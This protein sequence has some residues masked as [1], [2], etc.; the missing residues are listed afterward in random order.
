MRLIIL[1][2]LSTLTYV[3]VAQQCK[4]ENYPDTLTK[5][6][7]KDLF[8]LSKIPPLEVNKSLLK[9]TLP[10][11]VDNSPLSYFRPI[12]SQSDYCCGQAA[13]ILY[14]FTYEINR[15]RNLP[16][17]TTANQYPT[18]FA[19]NWQNG[20]DCNRGVSYMNSLEML[21]HTGTPNVADWGG[22]PD[23]GGGSRWLSGYTQYYNGMH[24]KVD[25]YYSFHVGNVEG[26]NVLK[27]WLH[28][29]NENSAV[30]GV[31]CIYIQ[32]TTP[33]QL[34]PA[35]TP[36]AGKRVITQWGASANHGM[37]IVGYNDSICWDYNNDGQ[38]TNN[39]DINSDGIVDMKD[40]EIGG[41]KVANDFGTG[42][43]N[44]GYCYV[45]YKT[46]ADKYGQGGIWNNAVHVVKPKLAYSPLMTIKAT[47]E[48]TSRQEISVEA[49]VSSNVTDTVP[50]HTL[51]R[52][53][54]NFQGGDNYMQ[55][56]TPSALTLPLEFGLDVTPL[57]NY[58]QSGQPARFFFRVKEYDRGTPNDGQITSL[59]LKDYS[60]VSISPSVPFPVA[61]Q[62]NSTT[63]LWMDHTPVFVRPEIVEDTLP[64]MTLY[65]DFTYQMTATN[66][67]PPYKWKMK[68][69]Y[70]EQ[71]TS[72]TYPNISTTVL[73]LNG[74][75]T[76][77]AEVNLNFN[78][79]FY[80]QTYNKMYVHTDGFI[81]F[82][83]ENLPWVYYYDEDKST[84]LKFMKGI[85]VFLSE[86]E[87]LSAPNGTWIEQYSDSVV[88]RWCGT[89]PD[90]MG[91]HYQV[92]F[93]IKLRSDGSINYY[94]GN[95]ETNGFQWAA[96][97][98]NG[99]YANWQQLAFSNSTFT[100]TGNKS[101][102]L[103]PANLNFLNDVTLSETGLLTGIV[104]ESYNNYPLVIEV[105]DN[106][107]IKNNKSIFVSSQGIQFEY[108]V[109]SGN[110]TLIEYGE[111]ATMDIT[112]RNIC[113]N[114]I[115]NI[116][117]SL[118]S[119][120]PFI[121][122]TDSVFSIA[123]IAASQVITVPAG[124]TFAVSNQVPDLESLPVT[125]EINASNMQQI[126]NE[127]LVA[128]RPEITL[129]TY[130][131]SG[132]AS[133]VLLSGDTAQLNIIIRNNSK[134]KLI[135]GSFSL[136]NI[137]PH[138]TSLSGS[139]VIDTLSSME[140]DTLVF[141]VAV[142]HSATWESIVN[143]SVEITAQYQFLQILPLNLQINFNSETYESADLNAYNWITSG[144]TNWYVVQPGH[145]GMYSARSGIIT[146]SQESVL[147]V[148]MNT[149][150][151]GDI[152]F[153]RKVS[154]EQNYDYLNFYIDNVLM[155][156]WS[157]TL[158]WQLCTYPVLAGTHTF[159]WTY[160]KDESVSSGSDC[161]WIDDII[162]PPINQSNIPFLSFSPS[163]FSKSLPPDAIETDTLYLSNIGGGNLSVKIRTINA[164]PWLSKSITGSYI[165]T[166]AAPFYA[167]DTVTVPLTLYN[168][169][170]DSEWIKDA[171]I[172]IPQGIT[173]LSATPFTGGSGGAMN[174]TGMSASG[175]TAK[176]HGEDAS[177]W[178]VV[179]GGEFAYS[180]ITLF[181]PHT[182]NSNLTLDYMIYGDIYGAVP[183]E[184]GGVLNI[185]NLGQEISWLTFSPAADTI[186]AS[187]GKEVIL[188]FNSAGLAQ[189]VYTCDIEI[190][191]NNSQIHIIPVQLT[192]SYLQ[193]NPDSVYKE[194]NTDSFTFSVI[195][196]HNYYNLPFFV[197]ASVDYPP[198]STDTTWLVVSPSAL[199]ISAYSS[200]PFILDFD[201]TGLSVGIYYATV[202]F[203]D[204]QYFYTHVPVT[205]NVIPVV[206]SENNEL[207]S[208]IMIYPN[209]AGNVLFINTGDVKLNSEIVIFNSTGQIVR[210][211]IS[212]RN[213]NAVDINGC[214]PGLYYIRITNNHQTFTSKFVKN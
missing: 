137:A 152:R 78:F 15:L 182:Y 120:S 212:D 140:I 195:S 167:G 87:M 77:K 98:S 43:G 67:Q 5:L 139:Y 202:I 187:A 3:A 63:T 36:E 40:W 132:T 201:A 38:F 1:I 145:T 9:A 17:N 46:L 20:P 72:E 13:S 130:F 11:S 164:Q 199:M 136:Q 181:V 194:L 68:M 106:Q 124:F 81:S 113:A 185:N 94:Y 101:F 7:E 93:A 171:G 96:G 158:N 184:T 48:H 24:N 49:G 10:V 90:Y 114:D 23:Y 177:G 73:N 211:F 200:S 58:I 108:V 27:N 197:A 51:E 122:L 115:N 146:H 173:L 89:I 79:P 206:S 144:N 52:T 30:G 154:S 95:C 100:L 168:G 4:F 34:L 76:G 12:W 138:I 125:F 74:W 180:T 33:S 26:L 179:R 174:Y 191:A 69:D 192:V 170:T 99:D 203:M 54:I 118:S 208:G 149:T 103:N 29:H 44:G 66:G 134:A 169:S 153:Y 159:K 105:T 83:D 214:P 151:D 210:S 59:S 56:G 111:Q 65:D 57:L 91:G 183:H 190:K 104:T 53:I 193:F 142:L 19:W 128:H 62:N 186:T 176:W 110:D 205:L 141:Q 6:S 126:R 160:E 178:G 143:A 55:G 60:S 97:I 213:H 2:I 31:A 148:E 21:K 204:Q 80:N 75:T 64:E 70:S 119:S 16:S 135:N 121:S 82:K 157:G 156:N 71:E 22:T 8:F 92:N 41:Y 147:S 161:S 133:P 35:G 150:A 116:E 155:D 109:E 39:I 188:T 172:I 14:M 25:E 123:S 198:A 45:M 131:I 189:G 175:D 85:A 196:V 127:T 32:F 129:L 37:V 84:L 163:S 207:V 88:I 28:N 117:F 18:H 162:F 165:I 102:K 166:S 107:G 209:P 86:V 42:W 47:I 61:I 112:L 50:E